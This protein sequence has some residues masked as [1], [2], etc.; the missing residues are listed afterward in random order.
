MEHT[1]GGPHGT[2]RTR[3]IGHGLRGS[4]QRRGKMLRG[5]MKERQRLPHPT[6][7]LNKIKNQHTRSEELLH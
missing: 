2:G 3:P 1:V 5:G 6:P 7:R 4:L